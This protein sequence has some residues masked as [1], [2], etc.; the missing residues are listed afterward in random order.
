LKEI[1]PSTIV[2][3]GDRFFRNVPLDALHDGEKFLIEKY[4]VV[5]ALGLQFTDFRKID[6]ARGALIFALTVN[7]P[8]FGRLDSALEETNG[9]ANIVTSV[10]KYLD[11]QFT[12]QRLEDELSRERDLAFVHFIS[13]GNFGG[14]KSRTFLQAYD[15]SISLNELEKFLGK[16][17]LNVNMVV[18][19]ACQT[20]SG[21]ERAILGLAG[22]TV[23]Q[24]AQAVLGSLWF[25]NDEETAR[26]MQYFYRNLYGG[27]M[28]KAEALQQ[29]KVELMHSDPHKTHPLIWSGFTLI[30]NWI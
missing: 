2:F 20:A 5:T 29:A 21:N 23:R 6:K 13:H 7:R 14:T 11:E 8:P 10:K 28:S 4:P 3:L 25:V 1:N 19:S 22:V 9:I 24:N 15:S 17:E 16:E 18:L 26:L 30:G 27:I 12:K